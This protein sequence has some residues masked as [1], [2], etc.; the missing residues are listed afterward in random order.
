ML[1]QTMLTPRM[2]LAP[3]Y[4]ARAPHAVQRPWFECATCGLGAVGGAINLGDP[5]VMVEIKTIMMMLGMTVPAS[6]GNDWF[7]APWSAANWE[8]YKAVLAKLPGSATEKTKLVAYQGKSGVVL[9]MPP[10]GTVGF[11]SIYGIAAMGN[12]LISQGAL[13]EASSKEAF[14]VLTAAAN[15]AASGLKPGDAGVEAPGAGGGSSN[16]LLIVAGVG[17]ALLVGYV[18]LKKK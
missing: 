7:N 11:P 3:R 13:T 6:A 12:R 14:P 16:T 10:T 2:N 18:L 1:G 8:A 15:K 5:A 4:H 17:V 9:G